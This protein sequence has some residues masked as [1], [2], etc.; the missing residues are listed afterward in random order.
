MSWLVEALCST[1]VEVVS[2]CLI[3]EIAYE[4]AF[5]K[6][7]L[8]NCIYFNFINCI[9]IPYMQNIHIFLEWPPYVLKTLTKLR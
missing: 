1:H 8:I 4:I 7:N 6:S 2:F 3:Y 9:Y 5:I